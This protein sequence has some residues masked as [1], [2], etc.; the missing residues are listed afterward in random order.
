LFIAVSTWVALV[1]VRRQV[2][3][4]TL[5]AIRTFNESNRDG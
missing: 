2:R 5:H 4:R 1:L 3:S